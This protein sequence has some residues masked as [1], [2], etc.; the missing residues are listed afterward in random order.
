[1]NHHYEMFHQID[2]CDEQ[3][4]ESNSVKASK[5]LS[6]GILDS[7]LNELKFELI[8]HSNQSDFESDFC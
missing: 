7:R 5:S 4:F 3:R 2:V 6:Y 1:M 8:H